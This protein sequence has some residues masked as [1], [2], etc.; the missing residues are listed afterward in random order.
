VYNHWLMSL[1][2]IILAAGRGKRMHSSTPKVL[3]RLAGKPLLEWVVRAAES[4]NPAGIYV[5]Y[6]HKG[7]HV[8]EQM[9]HFPKIQWVEQTEL[10]GTGHAVA[11]VL[12][13]LPPNDNVLILAG[14][15]PLVSTHSLQD[16]LVATPKNGLGIL[17]A[18]VNNP[19][20]LGRIV[21]NAGGYVTAIIEH[22]DA[23]PAELAIQEINTGILTAS[24][25]HLSA[26]L[27]RVNNTNAQQ[28]YYLTDI[29]TL[30]VEDNCPII[31]VS[32]RCE[33]EVQGI[34]DRSQ[35]AALERFYQHEAARK[36]MLSG[37][38]L[39]DPN[40]FDLRGELKTGQD[41]DID[42]NVIIEGKVTLG[43]GTRIGAHSIIRNSRIGNGVEIRPHSLIDGADISDNCI[44]GPFARIRPGTRLSESVHIGN[45]VETK[46]TMLGTGSKANHLSYL[47]DA[48][49]GSGVNIGAG[50]ITCNYDGVNKHKTVIGDG[51]FIGSDTQL[52]APITI[53]AGATVGAGATITKDVPANTL[54]VSRREQKV[55]ENWHRPQKLREN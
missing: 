21:R 8:R 7:E 53:G 13:H 26:W 49:I 32:A 11:Q 47:G 55:I 40:R 3:H 27:S 12:P 14:D 19:S 43:T 35:L 28:E 45:F 46:N 37:V 1:N 48:D 34:N 4:L 29:V 17:T 36:L 52:V 15:V 30:A 33:E 25:E 39:M 2:I 20:G 5:V 22:V 9:A 31:S 10:A 16:L 18:E 42:I 6:G 44:V 54:A 51:A 41:I 24:F 38:T 50:T 23:T